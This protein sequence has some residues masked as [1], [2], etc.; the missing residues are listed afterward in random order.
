MIIDVKKLKRMGITDYEFELDYNPPQN[1]IPLPNTTFSGAVK[2]QGEINIYKDYILADADIT[3]KLAGECSR[4]LEKSEVTIKCI[5]DEK[6]LNVKSDTEYYYLNEMLDLSS[7]VNDLII[8]NMPYIILCK[9]DCKGLCS[10]CG[11][12]LNKQKCNCE[13]L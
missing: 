5:L 7:A 12:N 8:M 13:N 2:V 11:A 4:C 10:K 3:F 9:E 6:F 1:L